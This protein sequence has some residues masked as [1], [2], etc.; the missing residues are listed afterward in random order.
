MALHPH[1]H[2]I[3]NVHFSNKPETKLSGFSLQHVTVT[4]N[5]VWLTMAI[6][7]NHIEIFIFVPVGMSW[8]KWYFLNN[9]AYPLNA[10][11]G[12]RTKKVTFKKTKRE[13]K[14]GLINFNFTYR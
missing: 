6:E 5:H 2:K 9:F 10:A 4:Q 8:R 1:H 7:R 11:R 13:S 14:S 12:C 3:S